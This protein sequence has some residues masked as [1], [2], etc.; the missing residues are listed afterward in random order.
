[1]R[2]SFVTLGLFLRCDVVK[3]ARAYTAQYQPDRNRNR[4]QLS[5]AARHGAFRSAPYGIGKR[6]GEM[7]SSSVE[8]IVTPRP[9]AVP[10][11]AAD[12]REAA[13]SQSGECNLH[14]APPRPRVCRVVSPGA[15]GAHGN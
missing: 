11:G 9:H 6:V 13:K 7:E 8:S 2:F 10:C 1:M 15:A 5:S 4:R 3:A 12:G 14:K